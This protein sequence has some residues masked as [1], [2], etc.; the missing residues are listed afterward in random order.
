MDLS[1]K[2]HGKGTAKGSKKTTASS[3]KGKLVATSTRPKKKTRAAKDYKVLNADLN[4]MR[5]RGGNQLT[6]NIKGNG[7]QDLKTFAQRWL[8]SKKR[9]GHP[10]LPGTPM[11][12]EVHEVLGLGC[13]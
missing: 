8:D 3:S 4:G 5:D 2:S 10:L 12:N 7:L 6:A 11:Y 1:S 9:T 13:P